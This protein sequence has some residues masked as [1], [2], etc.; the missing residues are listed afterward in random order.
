ME[1][2]HRRAVEIA[3]MRLANDTDDHV[4]GMVLAG[5]VGTRC[6]IGEV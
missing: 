3:A 2:G 5:H 6:S 1:G 4:V